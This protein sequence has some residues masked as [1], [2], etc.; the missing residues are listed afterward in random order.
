MVAPSAPLRPM[1]QLRSTGLLAVVAGLCAW[2]YLLSPEITPAPRAFI[3]LFPDA[4]KPQQGE[5]DQGQGQGQQKPDD[6]PG[7]Q[8]ETPEE[9][10]AQAKAQL[11]EEQAE[12]RPDFNQA[13]QDWKE[14]AYER[15]MERIQARKRKAAGVYEMSPREILA[16]KR[17]E[18]EWRRMSGRSSEGN[19]GERDTD[20]DGTLVTVTLEKPLGIEFIEINAREPCGAIVADVPVGYNAHKSGKIEIGDE[21]YAVDGEKVMGEPMAEAIVPIAA[22]EGEVELTF[23]RAYTE[24][25]GSR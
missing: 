1:R 4:N 14:V 9:E 2:P 7:Q 8:A 13:I 6:L 11:E 10:E 18:A 3:D 19:F 15:Q 23:F 20:E 16:K 21:L 25:R 22:K 17:R 12:T 24:N 5:R